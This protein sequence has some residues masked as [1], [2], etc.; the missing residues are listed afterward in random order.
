[1]ST[2]HIAF[3]CFAN[4]EGD[5]KNREDRY[6]SNR[7]GHGKITVTRTALEDLAKLFSTSTKTTF[8]ACFVSAGKP[9]A[10][11]AALD[12]AISHGLAHT[13]YCPRGRKAEGEPIPLLYNLEETETEEDHEPTLKNVRLADATAVFSC[14]LLDTLRAKNGGSGSVL[15]CERESR[16]CV[17]LS[18]FTNFA[19]DA[20]ELEAFLS[21]NPCRILNIAG[22]TERHQPGI[23]KH[24]TDV[25]SAV[26]ATMPRKAPSSVYP[27]R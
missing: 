24:V 22:N 5:R 8:P 17:V 23:H 25:L 20:A 1:M 12:F 14:P 7:H 13:G 21:M 3:D 18:S 2:R 10:Q 11:R 26:F 6:R 27:T 4:T 15:A 16:P 9:G 19:A